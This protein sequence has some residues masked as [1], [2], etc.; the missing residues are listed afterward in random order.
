MG[1]CQTSGFL[2]YHFYM[3]KHPLTLCFPILILSIAALATW[4]VLDRETAPREIGAPDSR[5]LGSITE[6]EAYYEVEAVYPTATPLRS[7]AGITADSEAVA[8]IEA[9]LKADIASFKEDSGILSLTEEDATFIGLSDT[10]KYVYGAEYSEHRGAATLSY[11]YSIYVDTLGVHPN[12]YHHSF[13]F[14]MSTGELLSLSSLFEESGYLEQ[15]SSIS[16]D[17]LPRIISKKTGGLPEEVNTDMLLSGTAPSEENFSTFYLT[18]A[19]LVIVF[20]PYQVGPWAIGTQTLPI[21]LSELQGL[22]S[23]YR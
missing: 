21:P 17:E 5:V 9:F 3:P 7:S 1:A 2:V 20:S 16:R 14:D 13:T 19:E 23:A 12:G 18:D 6:N 15:L 11:L 4:Y 8:T 10:R 22:R